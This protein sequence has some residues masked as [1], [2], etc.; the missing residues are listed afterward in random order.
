MKS[1]QKKMIT[2]CCENR[3]GVFPPLAFV[4]SGL[5]HFRLALLAHQLADPRWRI[6]Q[7]RTMSVV[8]LQHAVQERV[9]R[10][11][12]TRQDCEADE[13]TDRGSHEANEQRVFHI[14]PGPLCRELSRPAEYD[15]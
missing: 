3:S 8:V 12:K 15:R 11:A 9:G 14:L 2:E 4:G 6:V 10:P 1:V 13:G 5:S 7:I